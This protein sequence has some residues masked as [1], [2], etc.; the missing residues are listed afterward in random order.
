MQVLNHLLQE[1]LLQV[2]T[3]LKALSV[4]FL[5]LLQLEH[6]KTVIT[7]F[8]IHPKIGQMLKLYALQMEEI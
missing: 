2:T 6:L 4:Q 1:Q 5:A 3:V 8:R 7:I